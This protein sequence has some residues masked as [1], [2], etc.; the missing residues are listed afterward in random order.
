MPYICS[1]LS[2][3]Y[4]TL[5][6]LGRHVKVRLNARDRLR[7]CNLFIP[8]I[9]LW[10]T[11]VYTTFKIDHPPRLRIH[12]ISARQ[13]TGKAKTN[14]SYYDTIHTRKLRHYWYNHFIQSILR[15]FN[16][17]LGP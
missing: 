11:N 5:V 13:P 14:N 6:Q 8:N 9:P 4:H 12:L 16:G 7:A 3:A 1:F 15:T 2:N 10:L 17:T